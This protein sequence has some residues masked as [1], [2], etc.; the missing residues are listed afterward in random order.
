MKITIDGQSFDAAAG[1]TILDIARSHGI[2]IPALCW[3][4]R[5]GR[6][7]RC[8]ACVV[9]VEGT[10]GLKAACVHEVVDG[11]V[12]HTNTESVLST[13]RTVVELLLANGEHDCLS[14]EVN[15][16]CELQDM[17]Y[18]LGIEKPR[19]RMERREHVLDDSS[20]GI[21][22]DLKKC[23]HCGR[24]VTACN[25]NVMHEVLSFGW[26]GDETDIICDN[27]R[28]MGESTCVQCGECVQVC[29]VGALIFKPPV[30]AARRWEVE[31]KKVICP[32]CG[33]GC[34]IEIATKDN[35]Y[36]WSM[37]MEHNWENLPNKGMLCVKGRFGFDF[38]HRTD[39]L[40]SPLVRKDGLLVEVG[41]DE[42]LDLAAKRL[43]AIKETHGA[44]SIGCLSS[45]K[46][47]NEENYAMMRFARG[48]IG[49]NNVDHCARL[50]HSSTVAGLASTLGSGA[51]TN[52]MQ[53]VD[54]S[55]V[56]LITGS[57]TTWCHPVLGGM[58]KHAVKKKG[59][60]LI[61]VDPRE[62]D[63]AK[64]ADIH[65]RQRGGSDVVWL[66]GMQR[67]IVTEGWHDESYI[68]A[69]CE[70]WD[71]YRQSLEFYTLERVEALCG[72][73]P[74][75][76]YAAAK[77]F[78][79]SG[80]GALYFSMGITQHSHGVDN[81]K[82]CANLSLITGNLGVEG[83]GVNPLRGQV[84]VQGACDMGALPNVFSGY[85]PVTDSNVRQK[86]ADYWGISSTQ[87]DPKEGLAVTSMIETCGEGIR[88]LYIMGE[89]P[90]LSDPNL[91]HVEEQLRKLDILIVQD[92]FLTET[93]KMADI[94]F[95]A[96]T[97]AEKTGTFTNTERR[98]QLGYQALLPPP[99]V[100]Q[101]YQIIADIAARFG[102]VDFP[103]T[104]EGLFQQIK[105]L[106]P[107]YHGMTYTR[108]EKEGLRW[109]CPSEDHPGTPILHIGKIIRGKGLLSALDYRPPAEEPD[110]D[111]PFLLSTGR[112]LQHYH[113]G[114]M[115][116]R[117][118]VLDELVAQAEVEMHP[119]DAER[120]A[121]KS[122]ALVRVSTRRGSIALR[123]KVTDAVN[124]GMLYVPFHFVEAAAN[125][126][127]N[128][129]L[130]PVSKIPEYKVC[131]AS[132]CVMPAADPD[133]EKAPAQSIARGAGACSI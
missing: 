91:N 54:K 88:A 63:L 4:A 99:G 19:Y 69:R 120:L 32:Y 112:L 7:A 93:A 58:I 100:R 37:G 72:I 106:T 38:L 118:R 74:A 35:R 108:L 48:V 29:P 123:A 111:Y 15:G 56:I 109:P 36:L 55:D 90:M 27:D 96:A 116:R 64:I 83:G 84:N 53:D 101:D 52:S 104:P 125:R 70:G 10:R 5:T 51:M 81:V 47:T 1:Q 33:V 102:A 62:N 82:A 20:P 95:P 30:G 110:A 22:R 77:L 28:P 115:T 2:Y 59:V 14:C 44:N 122:G 94:V 61:V 117:S 114:S 8:R 80:V 97:F 107:S 3:H 16:A 43:L 132:I 85:Q 67:I 45:A 128:D 49:T 75:D 50:C 127:T 121:V 60:K 41:W 92:I 113:T 42:A 105:D 87:M 40:T 79:T 129:A 39:R 34:V 65:L 86:F 124:V 11:M 130:D 76:L 12:V 25:N 24:C 18:H 66:M 89:N 133:D 31:K 23:I 73:S 98:V 13:R 103:R 6:A 119:A 17:A 68:R 57:N 21:I 26:R 126:L 131:A 71:A 9:E 46:T 78:A